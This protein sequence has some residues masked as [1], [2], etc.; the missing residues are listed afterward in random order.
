[1]T[2]HASRIELHEDNGGRLWFVA[3]GLALDVTPTSA[4]VGGFVHDARL[5]GAEWDFGD[6]QAGLVAWDAE[7]TAGEGWSATGTTLRYLDPATC[8]LVAT[9]DGD[10]DRL[11]VERDGLLGTA[12]RRY[13]GD[14]A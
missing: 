12:A 10:E 13:L 8:R 4:D 2:D 7:P 14:A 3:D 9:Y 11:W 1:M 6:T 5:Y